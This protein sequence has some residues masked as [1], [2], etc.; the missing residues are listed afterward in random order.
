MDI[1]RATHVYG[2]LQSKCWRSSRNNPCIIWKNS[3]DANTS[4]NMFWGLWH[5]SRN[6]FLFFNNKLS[7]F[8]SVLMKLS[9]DTLI[10]KACSNFPYFPWDFYHSCH[11]IS[12][13][14]GLVFYFYPLI[15]WEL[16]PSD[17][18][19]LF[20]VGLVDSWAQMSTFSGGRLGPEPNLPSIGQ[21]AQWE[22]KENNRQNSLKVLKSCL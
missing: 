14:W 1:L 5:Y 11:F 9:A 12:K 21:I 2:R 3:N 22:Q 16:G 10:I 17:S 18:W 4:N 7:K 13:L 15:C 20:W 8:K 6:I 19:A